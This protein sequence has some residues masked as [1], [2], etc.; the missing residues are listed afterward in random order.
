M[1]F[2][3][4]GEEDRA[5]FH[6]QMLAFSEDVFSHVDHR[7]IKS[8]HLVLVIDVLADSFQE[9]PFPPQIG[10]VKASNTRKAYHERQATLEP[11]EVLLIL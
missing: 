1:D 6:S 10:G 8:Q 4:F 3:S 5:V 11:I 7:A 2:G 9:Y